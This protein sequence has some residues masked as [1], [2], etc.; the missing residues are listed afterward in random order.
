MAS[1]G[2]VAD[3]EQLRNVVLGGC[4]IQ[5]SQAET[6][7]SQAVGI[8]SRGSGIRVERIDTKCVVGCLVANL[9][10]KLICWVA[11]G[12]CRGWG[13][14]VITK[15]KM[16]TNLTI[17]FIFYFLDLQPGKIA[18]ILNSKIY[19]TFSAPRRLDPSQARGRKLW[20]TYLS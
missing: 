14:D 10:Y 19:A 20:A 9:V 13:E 3:L 16:S 15:K 6:N 4:G 17:F 1:R 2:V 5:V 11:S 8:S 7:N 18:E 12:G